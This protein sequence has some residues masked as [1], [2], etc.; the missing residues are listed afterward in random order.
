M[1]Q[2]AR[3][4][5]LDNNEIAVLYA[6]TRQQ[7]YKE[8]AARRFDGLVYSC[9]NRYKSRHDWEDL[10]QEGRYALLCALD[11]FDPA[12]ASF[13]TIAVH[14]IQG[15]VR[16]YLRDRAEAVRVPAWV[17]DHYRR[18]RATKAELTA[19]LGRE[20]TLCEVAEKL[21]IGME[22]LQ[23][24]HRSSPAAI[25]C[26]SFDDVVERSMKSGT[27]LEESPAMVSNIMGTQE[28]EDESMSLSV[29]EST[30]LVET[31]VSDL[32]QNHRI[33]IVDAR[34]LKQLVMA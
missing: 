9:C 25:E 16:H 1:G 26:A 30:Y 18:E 13:S 4:S 8:E 32:M 6:T 2:Y 5:H 27:P 17:Q 20:P 22:R 23:E 14:Y 34:R 21:G 31:P 33:G 11:K 10:V 24:V 19:I 15:K 3:L 28:F 29:E 7:Q 12:E